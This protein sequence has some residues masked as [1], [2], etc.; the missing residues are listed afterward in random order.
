MTFD[1][2][3]VA[4]YAFGLFLLYVLLRIVLVPMRFVVQV[5]VHGAAG[6]LLLAVVNGIGNALGVARLY[7]PINPVTA[8]VSG[9]LGVPGVAA[10]ITLRWWL[11]VPQGAALPVVMPA[12]PAV[13]PALPVVAP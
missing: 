7:V 3:T 10:L 11:G 2:V 1:P 9:F 13:M 12:L 8:L 4:A 6:V 5:L